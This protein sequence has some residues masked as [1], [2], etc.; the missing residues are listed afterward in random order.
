MVHRIRLPRRSFMQYYP[1]LPGCRL[2]CGSLCLHVA[3]DEEL[4]V[5]QVTVRHA[6]AGNFTAFILRSDF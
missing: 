3:M 2:R 6:A 5:D 4:D 1:L